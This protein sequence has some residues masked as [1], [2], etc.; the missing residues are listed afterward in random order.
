[1]LCSQLVSIFQFN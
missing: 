1:L